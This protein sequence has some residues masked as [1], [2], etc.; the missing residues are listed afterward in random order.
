M[1]LKGNLE[2]IVGY[3]IV[4]RKVPLQIY[5][6]MYISYIYIY[7][8]IIYIYMYI[9]Y[10]YVY[11]IYIY[12][13][14]H[15]HMH[16]YIYS[17]MLTHTYV[18]PIQEAVGSEAAGLSGSNGGDVDQTQEMSIATRSGSPAFW[19]SYPRPSDR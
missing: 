18:F 17:Y 4:C 16:V 13:R 19:S 14:K 15:T 6:Y 3:Q 2:G 10:I 8:Y 12:T 11:I 7:V 1:E 9:S 5:I